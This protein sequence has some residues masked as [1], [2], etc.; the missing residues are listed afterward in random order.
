M[1]ETLIPSRLRELR[2][3]AGVSQEVVAESCCISRVTLARYENGT[4]LPK[5]QNA[6]RLAKYYG[7]PTDYLMEP[8]TGLEQPEPTPLDQKRTEILQKLESLPEDKLED[9]LR[10]AE[11]VAQRK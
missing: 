7:V 10:Y 8:E 3:K 1:Q 4:R 9:V 5:I 6:A 11:F 2:E